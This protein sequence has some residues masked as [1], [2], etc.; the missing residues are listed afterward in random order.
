MI[1]SSISRK[2]D[3]CN[4]KKSQEFRYEEEGQRDDSAQQMS[5]DAGLSSGGLLVA[6][7]QLLCTTFFL[8]RAAV[9]GL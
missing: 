5:N 9:G 4:E 3:F 1:P 8:H 7:L 6:R 2:L